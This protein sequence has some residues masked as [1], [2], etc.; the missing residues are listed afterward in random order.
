M[1]PVSK[2]LLQSV[3][4]DLARVPVDPGDLASI[5]AQLGGQLDGLSRLDEL[6]LLTVEPVTVV[7]PP[8]EAPHV[9]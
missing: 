2:E 6:D 4:A 8:R 3:A 9:R 7:Q 1:T 5:V